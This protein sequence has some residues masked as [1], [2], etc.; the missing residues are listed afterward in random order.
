M[1]LQKR[2]EDQL[3]VLTATCERFDAA[4]AVQLKDAFSD[5]IA[6]E[7]GRV[8]MDIGSVSFMDSSGLGAMV[9]SMK[10][11]DRGRK[12]ELCSLSPAVQKVFTLTRMYSIFS[13][14]PDLET[15]LSQSATISDNV[16]VA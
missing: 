6:A 7:K 1:I 12:L 3:V 4:N 10:L 2:Y 9:A 13:I 11:L 14:H 16:S 15:A 8:L 5:A